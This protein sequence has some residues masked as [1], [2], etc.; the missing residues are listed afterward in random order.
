MT[1]DD[2]ERLMAVWTHRSGDDATACAAGLTDY[3]QPS[4]SRP[5]TLWKE[6]HRLHET[7]KTEPSA[8]KRLDELTHVPACP[9]E[10]D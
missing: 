8:C 7:C 9:G 4:G 6:L 3:C 2:R 5:T 10:N 1:P